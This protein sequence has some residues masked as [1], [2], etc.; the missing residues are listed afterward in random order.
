M[1]EASSY[2]P[3]VAAQHKPIRAST[4]FETHLP[5]AQRVTIRSLDKQSYPDLIWV[6]QV[7]AL[8]K[9]DLLDHNG[10]AE[11]DGWPC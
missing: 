1:N 2:V 5:K 4:E 6:P 3:L 11:K 10:G 8:V 7:S 9:A